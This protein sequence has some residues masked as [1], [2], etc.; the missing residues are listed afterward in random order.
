[1]RRLLR[2]V[3]LV[4]GAASW[5][6]PRAPRAPLRLD[7]G[8]WDPRS[9]TAVRA[10][11]SG[12]RPR[13]SRPVDVA[14]NGEPVAHLS[15][16]RRASAAE[17]LRRRARDRREQQHARAADRRRTS[18]PR[19]ASRRAGAQPTSSVAI[20]DLQQHRDRVALP[21]T[22][23]AGG[24][25]RRARSS[26]RPARLRARTSTTRSRRRLDCCAR[27]RSR[28]GSIVVLSDGADTGSG[29]ARARGRRAGAGGARPHLRCRPALDGVPTPR[30]CEPLAAATRRVLRGSVRRRARA[31]LSTQL[32]ARL[33]ERVPGPRTARWPSATSRSTWP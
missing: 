20:V 12:G 9:P 5:R 7:A 33:A 3:A 14:E 29:P 10:H 21:F 25:R 27:R 19:G 23:D 18:R 4:C 6:R 11:A 13:S 22:T 16:G 1:M 15:V 31:D 26:T 32:G 28:A 30:R 24:D 17:T 8:R 2:R